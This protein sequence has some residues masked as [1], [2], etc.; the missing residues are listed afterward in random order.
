MSK[1]KELVEK[2]KVDEEDGTKNIVTNKFAI[3]DIIAFIDLSQANQGALD[4]KLKGLPDT[5]DKK[6]NADKKKIFVNL[7]KLKQLNKAIRIT[8]NRLLDEY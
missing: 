8:A 7:A 3:Q 4:R 1:A 5:S 2:Y 6:F